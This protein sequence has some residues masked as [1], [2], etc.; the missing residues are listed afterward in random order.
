MAHR[1]GDQRVSQ[2]LPQSRAKGGIGNDVAERRH[3]F[4]VRA[5]DRAPETAAL[6]H[7]NGFDWR[8][9]E[10]GEG[11][12][13]L[14]QQ[15]GAVR[16]RNRTVAGGPFIR[17]DLEWNFALRKCEGEEQRHRSAA[18]DEHRPGFS[19]QPWPTS[20]SMSAMDL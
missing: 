19:H 12:D 5:D 18:G 6:R 4:F 16:E 8:A 1:A 14:E 13:S 7:V 15:S 9:R 10:P 3:A 2:A 20:D 17:A 11:A